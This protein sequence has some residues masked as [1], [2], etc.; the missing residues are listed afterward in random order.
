MKLRADALFIRYIRSNRCR[1]GEKNGRV[2]RKGHL[3][4]RD[5]VSVLCTRL[6]PEVT[7]EE[8]D[9]GYSNQRE[10]RC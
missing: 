10:I 3:T 7:I 9:Y 6:L 5:R 8:R 2:L 4:K 1:G